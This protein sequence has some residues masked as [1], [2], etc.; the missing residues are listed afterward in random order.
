MLH[1]VQS[2]RWALVA[3]VP[4]SF[5]ALA[6]RPA[7]SFQGAR[8]TVYTI[9]NDAG[10]NAVIALARQADGSLA[11]VPGS[12]FAADG[13]GLAGGDID[14]QGAIQ[15]HGNVLLAVNPGSDSIAVFR[16][17]AGGSLQPVEGSPFPSGG[18]NP[19]SLSVQGDLVYVAN[20]GPDYAHPRPEGTRRPN[21][22]G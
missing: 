9:N 16:L 19:L 12:P 21:I 11:E 14:E 2:V 10:K 20:Q 17:S 13:K 6:P 3:A 15:V 1:P 18:P 4:L 22:T 5:A 8:G 7:A